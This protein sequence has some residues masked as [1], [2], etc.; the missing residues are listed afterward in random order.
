[1]VLTVLEY[2]KQFPSKGKILS[3]K[4]I[5]RRCIDGFLPSNHHAR[6]LPCESGESKKGVWIIEIADES[7]PEIVATKVSPPKPDIKTINRK[8]FS[9]R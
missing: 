9:F 5:I 3:S 6:Q 1:M 4:T 8:Y 2:A 7:L